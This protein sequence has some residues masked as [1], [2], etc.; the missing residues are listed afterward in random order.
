MAWKNAPINFG[1]KVLKDADDLTK[2]IT[3]DML[4]QVVV[5]S[6]VDKGAYRGNHRVGIGS[7]DTTTNI[8][9]TENP[10]PKGIAK[11]QSGGGIGKITYISNG[12]PY[13]IPLENGWSQQAPLGVYTL[14]FQTVLNKYK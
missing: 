7:I 9:D 6:P 3:G 14:S 1:I 11:I 10:L 4:Q 8:N 13:A 12:L 2:K 5:R